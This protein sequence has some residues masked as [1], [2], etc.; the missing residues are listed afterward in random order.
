MNKILY[1]L[2]FFFLINSGLQAAVFY[3]SSSTGS[4]SYNSS[5][6]KNPATP[7]K[8][9]AKIGLSWSV[10]NPGDSIL[11]KRGDTFS[12]TLK[13]TKSGTP[14][15][16]ITIGA[17]GSGTEKPVIDGRLLL[18]NWVNLG[19][20]IWETS[21]VG[22]T[23]QPSAL[24]IND[25]LEPLG[26]YPNI[27][28]PNRGY[29]TISSHP[30]GSKTTFTDNTLPA[31]PNW[32]G[33]EVVVRNAHWVLNRI[34][35]SSHSGQT[36]T[37]SSSAYYEIK[38][39]TGYFFQNHPA[40]LDRDGEW[41]YLA[42]D[43]KV[44]IYSATDPNTKTI[45]VTNID[46]FFDFSSVSD[47]VIDGFSMIGSKKLAIN[48]SKTNSTTIKNCDFITSGESA[49]TVGY[50]YSTNI[51]CDSISLINNTFFNTQHSCI[52]AR[53]SRLTIKGNTITNTG[54]VP[55]MSVNGQGG[56]GINCVGDNIT[57]ERNIMEN[58]GYAA[59][60]F[61]GSNIL[62]DKNV[63]N[64][65]CSV[66]DDGGAIYTQ[67]KSTD[68]TVFVNR[69]ITNNIVLNGI[70]A[71]EGDNRKDGMVEGIYLDDYTANAEVT[72]N[73]VANCASSGIFFHNAKKS[74]AKNNTVFSCGIG[75]KL[76]HDNIAPNSPIVDCD[77]QNNLLV[78]GSADLS[79]SLLSYY[80][81]DESAFPMLGTLDNNIYCQPFNKTDYIKYSSPATQK[82]Y[83][84]NLSEW[85]SFGGYDLH[86]TLSPK[87][88]PAYEQILSG[89][90]IS[91][92]K[93]EQN[94]SSWGAYN[95]SGNTSSRVKVDGQLDGGC[96]A[97]TVTGT[98]AANSSFINTVLP[99]ITAGKNYLL[100]IS[101]KS[102][103]NGAIALKLMQ[104][105]SPYTAG[106]NSISLNISPT[107]ADNEIMITAM[108]TVAVPSLIIYAGP[109]DGT[110]YID[111]V[112][113]Y[114]VT[115]INP[116][117]YV[118][119]EYND[120][121]APKYV[122]ADRDY[123][124][125]SGNKYIGGSKISIPAFGSVVLLKAD[126]SL[127]VS[128][129]TLGSVKAMGDNENK[130]YY[131]SATLTVV[132]N[133][134]NPVKNA[135]V[136]GSF[137]GDFNEIV[138]GVTDSLGQ[139]MYVSSEYVKL[140]NKEKEGEEDD[141]YTKKRSY[142][143]FEFC[144]DTIT[145]E[146]LL[147]NSSQNSQTCMESEPDAEDTLKSASLN[148]D[149][150]VISPQSGKRFLVYPNPFCNGEAVVLYEGEIV[151]G[152]YLNVV[153][154]AG[155][156][157]YRTEVTKSTTTLSRSNFTSGTFL[158]TIEADGKLLKTSRLIVR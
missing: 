59:V 17:Y 15:H 49:V 92:G 78:K 63:I 18:D 55:G 16:P 74:S 143:D 2:I 96:L 42:A 102:T 33:A 98:G 6:A 114:E 57:I 89:N 146:F 110:I 85:Q 24:T 130:K 108:A 22:L 104:N 14:G 70:G 66:L 52:S 32:T 7:W 9:L 71:P 156:K 81:I 35:A 127:H 76:N 87:N 80:T 106:S 54:I 58:L 37:L 151:K 97:L 40:T 111:N 67:T 136:S 36:I 116:D 126:L 139:V 105:S 82:S 4:D 83:S 5:Q 138:T 61:N 125:P 38:N 148:A 65:Y 101:T 118:R 113:F 95:P 131:G 48:M 39:G 112:E 3:V 124:T 107:R 51:E 153:D 88:F 140:K 11:F 12:G 155:K 94:V 154:M 27:D 115:P 69:K 47:I 60:M 119:F 129:I 72:G 41:C 30:T 135:N 141:E 122:V 34:T 137:D 31:S 144:V 21:N 77:I 100:K 134:G 20:N 25:V 132:D 109:E 44:R 152:M 149:D 128:S 8:T 86:T 10:I 53:A 117:N 23:S 145:H 93:F 157:V 73:S 99:A 158:I 64:N 75:M 84:F 62:I 68:L 90:G 121:D 43:K 28:A 123:M 133:L 46:K 50:I 56:V 26:R 45:K 103:V 147:Y 19:G 91:N 29:L 142:L 120:T 150:T 79:K 1:F 13:I